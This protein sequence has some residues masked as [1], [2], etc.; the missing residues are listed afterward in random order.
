MTPLIHIAGPAITVGAR[1]RQR[2]AWC[3]ATMIDYD[4]DRIAI[5]DGPAGQDPTPATWPIGDLI[6]VDGHASWTVPHEDDQPLPDDACA[7]LDAE[8]TR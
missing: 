7:C 6:A 8:V 3:G 2:C 5:P 1:L 4:L